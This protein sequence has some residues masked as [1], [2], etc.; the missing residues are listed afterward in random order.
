MAFDMLINAGARPDVDT[1]G[2][3][4]ILHYAILHIRDVKFVQAMRKADLS[5]VNLKKPDDDGFTALDLLVLRAGAEW[6]DHPYQVR[7]FDYYKRFV[8][9]YRSANNPWLHR[10]IGVADSPKE[11][12]EVIEALEKLYRWTQGLQ[13]IQKEEKFP[14]LRALVERSE[15]FKDE[16]VGCT[17]GLPGAWPE[18]NGL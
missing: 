13:G 9:P 10:W 3:S 4:S 7:Q 2:G 5:S 15:Y 11:E 1:P 17:K 18:Q 14:P 12:C 8:R 16:P 6:N